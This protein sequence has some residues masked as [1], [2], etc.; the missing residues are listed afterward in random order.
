M[1]MTTTIVSAARKDTIF[2]VAD[3]MSVPRELASAVGNP[4]QVPSGLGDS[5]SLDDGGA[6]TQ[7]KGMAD[8]YRMPGSLPPSS[9][10]QNG[11]PKR[12]SSMYIVI[13]LVVRQSSSS[14]SYADYPILHSKTL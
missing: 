14:F 5:S 3:E 8:I 2:L 10:R 9:R 7:A 4:R 12:L 6:T 13:L 11:K 1:L